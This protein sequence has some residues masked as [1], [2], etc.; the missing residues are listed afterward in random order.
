MVEQKKKIAIFLTFLLSAVFPLQQSRARPPSAHSAKRNIKKTPSNSSEKKSQKK[1]KKS[2][3]T[4]KGEIKLYPAKKVPLLPLRVDSLRRIGK[5][6]L[7]WEKIFLL[8]KL[9]KKTIV[10]FL[11]SLKKD[12]LRE[13]EKFIQFCNK[14]RE[15]LLCLPTARYKNR[16]EY[17]KIKA[18]VRKFPKETII[19][20]DWS[21]KLS[22]V[23]QMLPPQSYTVVDIHGYIRMAGAKSLD[24]KVPGQKDKKVSDIILQTK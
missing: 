6:G 17:Q 4:E 13:L 22:L 8:K 9:G 1:S 10:L 23:G 12:A 15:K 14:Y 3:K 19:I 21:G 20:L 11:F 2:E 5:S 18:I 16:K 24:Q 7:K